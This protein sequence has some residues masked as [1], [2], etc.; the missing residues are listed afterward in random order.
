MNLYWAN[1]DFSEFSNFASYPIGLNGVLW[2]I[3]DPCL[4]AQKSENPSYRRRI[5]NANSPWEAVRARL[6]SELE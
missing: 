6:I 5:Q 3:F 1:N 4:Q 2:P